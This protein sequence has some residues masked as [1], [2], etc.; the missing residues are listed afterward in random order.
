MRT[1]PNLKDTEALSSVM[2]QRLHTIKIKRKNIL[3]YNRRG[4]EK[5]HDKLLY[6][7]M[8]AGK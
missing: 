1:G 7:H 8:H 3:H 6:L 4:T 5:T 2:I